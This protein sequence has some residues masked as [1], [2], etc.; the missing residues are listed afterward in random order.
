MDEKLSEYQ[1]YHIWILIGAVVIIATI[2]FFMNRHL[3]RDVARLSADLKK[4]EIKFSK[5]HQDQVDAY[6]QL[7]THFY[8]FRAATQRILY[9]ADRDADHHI[10]KKRLQEYL[11]N[12]KQLMHFFKSNRILFPEDTCKKIDDNFTVFARFTSKVFKDKEDLENFETY[13]DANF[14][15]MYGN[16]EGEMDKIKQRAR[17]LRESEEYKEAGKKMWKLIQELENDFRKLVK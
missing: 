3:K 11:V 13:F 16:A 17:N 10:H 14:M 5:Y 2:Q 9:F 15:E 6:K 8:E 1:Q 12:Q 4:A 7:Y